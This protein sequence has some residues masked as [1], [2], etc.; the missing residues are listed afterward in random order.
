MAIRKLTED[1]LLKLRARMV[2]Q[3][4]AN[5]HPHPED[6]ASEY[7]IRLLE[8]LHQ[9]STVGQAYI[10]II[11]LQSGRKTQNG[12]SNENYKA[13][14]SLTM[15]ASSEEQEKFYANQP[16][17]EHAVSIDDRLDLERI[18]NKI[19][20][21]RTIHIF[22]M[23]LQGYVLKDIAKDLGLTESRINQIVNRTLA[24]LAIS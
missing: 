8:G 1:V 18:L 16:C 5:Q 12:K 11:R 19:K 24:D 10:D 15:V 7:V 4:S 6:I 2:K 14:Q 22:K 20:C 9:R 3:A 23:V 17:M 21:E 13:R